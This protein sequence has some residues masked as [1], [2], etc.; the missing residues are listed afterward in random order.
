MSK[1]SGQRPRLPKRLGPLV[2][3]LLGYLIY[4]ERA[5]TPR[6]ETITLG[7]LDTSRIATEAQVVAFLQEKYSAK[8]Q[9]QAKKT[10]KSDEDVLFEFL[11]EHPLLV[12][13][14]NYLL[15]RARQNGLRKWLGTKEIQEKTPFYEGKTIAGQEEAV[16]KMD[17]Q[18]ANLASLLRSDY[19][20]QL[21]R[22]ASEWTRSLGEIVRKELAFDFAGAE[23]VDDLYRLLD[24]IRNRAD[25]YILLLSLPLGVLNALASK[26]PVTRKHRAPVVVPPD[27]VSLIYHSFAQ[28]YTTEHLSHASL[29]YTLCSAGEASTLAQHRFMLLAYYLGQSYREQLILPDTNLSLTREWETRMV[30]SPYYRHI[31][32]CPEDLAPFFVQDVLLESLFRIIWKALV[33]RYFSITWPPHDESRRFPVT[34][35]DRLAVRRELEE[36]SAEL[37]AEGCFMAFHTLIDRV[38]QETLIVE[39]RSMAIVSYSPVPSTGA[40]QDM[41]QVL[42][43][44]ISLTVNRHLSRADSALGAQRDTLMA[45]LRT[46]LTLDSEHEGTNSVADTWFASL[47]QFRHMALAPGRQCTGLEN[48]WKLVLAL[49]RFLAQQ[50]PIEL[51]PSQAIRFL[52]LHFTTHHVLSLAALLE[53]YFA[54]E[55]DRKESYPVRTLLMQQAL[56]LFE[57]DPT[58]M[59]RTR[60]E[61]IGYNSPSYTTLRA[62][63]ERPVSSTVARRLIE[64]IERNPD[65]TLIVM[66][67]RRVNQAGENEFN[68][69][70][71]SEERT[72]G[73]AIRPAG[74][75]QLLIF[76]VKESYDY[77]PLERDE[78]QR[79]GGLPDWTLSF[80]VESHQR[81]ETGFLLH[82]GQN[83]RLSEFDC[84]VEEGTNLA[85]LYHDREEW[86]SRLDIRTN[87]YKL[88]RF[89]PLLDQPGRRTHVIIVL[90][91]K[92]PALKRDLEAHAFATVARDYIRRRSLIPEE[93][94][95]ISADI[96]VEEEAEEEMIVERIAS[97]EVQRREV[98]DYYA[99]LRGLLYQNQISKNQGPIVYINRGEPESARFE[100]YQPDLFGGK[101][102]LTVRGEGLLVRMVEGL[103]LSVE[104]Y[105]Q[106]G[107]EGALRQVYQILRPGVS[108]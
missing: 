17:D 62:D 22:G 108:G 19:G 3:I 67:R 40:S 38:L 13:L 88:A 45:S 9:K 90:E 103:V 75:D 72:N 98:R 55:P 81:D 11:L 100:K 52:E 89:L 76:N 57:T 47:D 23:R 10:L 54:V 37:E 101:V 8:K 74:G 105:I 78:P 12:I 20:E 46:C 59:N 97:I 104:E 7:L 35:V 15:Q 39:P 43:T 96:G 16:G 85:A 58:E 60:L 79:A 30:R 86:L 64:S 1:Q 83:L 95:F 87:G 32:S 18:D 36:I 5:S 93:K 27:A 53:D 44:C 73:C 61:S 31:S 91:R 49:E 29:L 51:E 69:L 102:S 41:S 80:I 94:W 99:R 56:A 6:G 21:R 106:E 26:A 42:E 63:P 71:L 33:Y 84:S 25:E 28:R 82:S 50:G 107:G 70:D 4:A 14:I 92:M 77:N 65:N 34:L 48:D 2:P 66:R 68:Y 24:Q